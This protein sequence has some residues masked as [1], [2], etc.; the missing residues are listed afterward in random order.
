MSPKERAAVFALFVA[1]KD[2]DLK[3][4]DM[5]REKEV[6]LANKDAELANKDAELA[7]VIADNKVYALKSSVIMEKLFRESYSFTARGLLGN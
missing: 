1:V 6:K 4:S 5:L 2:K 3:Y 7:K